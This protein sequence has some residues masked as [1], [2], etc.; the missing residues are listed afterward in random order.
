MVR[1]MS[2]RKKIK[3]KGTSRRVVAEKKKSRKGA[4]AAVSR[5]KKSAVRSGRAKAVASDSDERI[6]IALENAIAGEVQAVFAS[7]DARLDRIERVLALIEASVPD[8]VTFRVADAANE[9]PLVE[10]VYED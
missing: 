2:V 6:S 5:V 9:E 7:V 1:V 8:L 4:V 10:R 3:S